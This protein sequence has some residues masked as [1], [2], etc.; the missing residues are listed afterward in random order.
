MLKK[1]RIFWQTLPFQIFLILG[2]LVLVTVEGT[3]L[4]RRRALDTLTESLQS[5]ARLAARLS[6]EKLA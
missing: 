5:D 3:R 6:E 4:L 2:L 1:R